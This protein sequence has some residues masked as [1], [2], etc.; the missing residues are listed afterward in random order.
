[1]LREFF[2][3]PRAKK[4][5]R[6]KNETYQVFEKNDSDGRKVEQCPAEYAIESPEYRRDENEERARRDVLHECV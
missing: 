6:Y 4:E 1:M 5:R 3:F 2:S